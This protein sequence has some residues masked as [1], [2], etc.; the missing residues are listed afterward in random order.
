MTVRIN[1]GALSLTELADLRE[2][3]RCRPGQRSPETKAKLAE[4][5]RLIAAYAP[6]YFPG[7][8]RNRQAEGV[9]A[10]LRRYAGT[11]WLRTRSD[12]TCR[13]RDDRRRMLWTI[14][15]LRPVPPG[16]RRIDQILARRNL[17]SAQRI[18]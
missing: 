4:C 16:V 11:V 5:D 14:M 8:S 3:L 9:A 12:E 15:K 7:A 13:H 1:I 17:S 10:D 2:Q 18:S 6:T